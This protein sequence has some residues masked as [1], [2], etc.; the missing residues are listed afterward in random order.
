MLYYEITKEIQTKKI[1]LKHNQKYG[2]K[3]SVKRIASQVVALLKR[4]FLDGNIHKN[5]RINGN[6]M[7]DKLVEKQEY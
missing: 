6:N 7:R 2:K 5:R 3:D 4:F 1:V